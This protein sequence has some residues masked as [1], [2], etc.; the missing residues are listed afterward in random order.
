[1]I[2]R[3]EE[4]TKLKALQALCAIHYDDYMGQVIAYLLE[5]HQLQYGKRLFWQN[6][7]GTVRLA[8]LET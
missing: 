7:H 6:L 3:L 5:E 1:M 4:E 8:N 2:L